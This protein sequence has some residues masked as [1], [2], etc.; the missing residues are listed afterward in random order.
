MSAEQNIQSTANINTT[1]VNQPQLLQLTRANRGPSIFE[2]VSFS[3]DPIR[4]NWGG[5]IDIK[6]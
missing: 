3:S 5:N 2:N 6:M 4:E 1:E